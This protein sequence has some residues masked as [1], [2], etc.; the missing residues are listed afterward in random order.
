MS[1]AIEFLESLGCSP[2]LMQP[3][4]AA[5]SDAVADLRLDERKRVALLNRDV[6]A[7]SGLLGG[8]RKMAMSVATPDRGDEPQEMPERQD[9]E[10]P[11]TEEQPR[12]TDKPS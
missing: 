2:A 1:K 5:Y 9:E 6:Q 3:S 8:R 10:Q 12:E 4:L 7:L 11:D